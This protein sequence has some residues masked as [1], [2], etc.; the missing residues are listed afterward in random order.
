MI[1][2]YEKPPIW[3]DLCGAFKIRPKNV[4]FTYGDTL[5]NPDNLQVPPDIVAHEELHAEQQKH[6]DIDAV[7]WWG[8]YLRDPEFR[9]DQEARAYG[10]QYAKI[11]QFVKD[12]NQRNGHLMA[13]ASSLSG[14]LYN[15]LIA[16]SEAMKLIRDYSGVKR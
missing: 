3:D 11:C 9:L 6:N 2:K 10:K 1:I 7:L 5:Y 8:K 12:R 13:L 4:F 15:N 16:H 14:P